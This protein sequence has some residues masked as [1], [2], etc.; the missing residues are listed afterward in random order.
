MQG[1]DVPTNT[2]RDV[3][4]NTVTPTPARCDFMAFS[5]ICADA[6]V[7]NARKRSGSAE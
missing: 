7:G 1:E 6:P 3:F 5:G 4:E 2:M